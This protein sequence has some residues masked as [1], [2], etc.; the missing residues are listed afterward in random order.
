LTIAWLFWMPTPR[1]IVSQ[2]YLYP[3]TGLRSINNTYDDEVSFS[4][5]KD[6][7]TFDEQLWPKIFFPI[8]SVLPLI[9]AV[10]MF[11][12]TRA[13]VICV[14]CVSFILLVGGLS[15]AFQDQCVTG[16]GALR[17]HIDSIHLT[18]EPTDSSWFNTHDEIQVKMGSGVTTAAPICQYTME[19]DEH[20]SM[21]EGDRILPHGVE[22]N[23]F[24]DWPITVQLVEK[25]SGLTGEDDT[26]KR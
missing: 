4:S 21:G 22:V 25:D 12:I 8:V 13:L 3:Y 17:V 10:S 26:S 23:S 24:Y 16:N 18:S 2:Y 15:G 20:Y 7:N 5:G 14:P 11:D 9:I 6:Y 19:E 1:S